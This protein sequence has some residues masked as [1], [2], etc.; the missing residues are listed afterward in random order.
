MGTECN[1]L[2]RSEVEKRCGLSR[3]TIYRQMKEG[4][5]PHPVKLP[6]GRVRWRST[7]IDKFIGS[8]EKTG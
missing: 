7:D 1:L 8:L 4:L 3:P 2:R 5:F 6:T